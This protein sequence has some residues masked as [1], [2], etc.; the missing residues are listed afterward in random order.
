M[1]DNNNHVLDAFIDPNLTLV[2]AAPSASQDPG[3][4]RGLACE[5]EFTAV[6]ARIF[7]TH[8]N[9]A[10]AIAAVRPTQQR[11]TNGHGHGTDSPM[12]RF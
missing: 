9:A 10:A 1:A 4:K 6:F 11:S 5:S 12:S 2:Q 3:Q 7:Q 8:D